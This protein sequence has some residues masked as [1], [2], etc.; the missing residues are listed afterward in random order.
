MTCIII[1]QYSVAKTCEVVEFEAIFNSE[2]K[3]IMAL[4]GANG[5]GGG[6]F[7]YTFATLSYF[8]HPSILKF[9]SANCMIE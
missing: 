9:T 6:N 5:F 2:F 8:T 4:T 7:Y 1:I 3:N